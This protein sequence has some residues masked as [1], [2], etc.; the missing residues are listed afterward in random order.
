MTPSGGEPELDN[1]KWKRRGFFLKR[2]SSFEGMN[3]LLDNIYFLSI[4]NDVK[5]ESLA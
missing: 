2:L 4:I 3:F 5:T 1:E